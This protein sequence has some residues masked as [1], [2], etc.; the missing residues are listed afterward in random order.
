MFSA[1]R[2]GE[3]EGIKIG[4]FELA[5]MVGV[6]VGA[7][8]VREV[9]LGGGGIVAQVWRARYNIARTIDTGPPTSPE[10]MGRSLTYSISWISAQEAVHIAHWIL[11]ITLVSL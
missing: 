4:E 9:N 2:Y 8:W 11:K 3:V 7:G 5:G 1:S 6:G 10:W